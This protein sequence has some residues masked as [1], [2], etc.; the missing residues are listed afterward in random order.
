MEQLAHGIVIKAGAYLSV[1]A[2]KTVLLQPN[3]QAGTAQAW[4]HP[5]QLPISLGR[6]HLQH[7]HLQPKARLQGGIPIH[8]YRL[9]G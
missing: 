2:G 4:R 6:A 3:L 8:I 5:R 9:K 7:G 1:L